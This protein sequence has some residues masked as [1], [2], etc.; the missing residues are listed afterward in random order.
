MQ[1]EFCRVGDL[2]PYARNARTHS[3]EQIAQIAA[4]IDEFGMVGAVVVRDGVIAKGHGTLA[5]LRKLYAAGMSVYPPPGRQHGAQPFAADAVP[6]IDATGWTDAQFRAYVI[7]DNKLSENAGWDRELLALEIGDLHAEGFNLDLLGFEVADLDVLLNVEAPQY[8]TDEDDTPAVEALGVSELGDIWKCGNHRVMC[9]DSTVS[10][11][12]ERLMA[13][14]VAALLHADPPYGMGKERDGVLN[15]NLYGDELSRFQMAWWSAYRPHLVSN[16]SAYVWGSAPDLWRFWYRAGL[17]DTERLELRNEIVWDKKTIPGMASPDLTQ[18]PEASERCLFF[19]LGNQFIGNVNSEDFPEV[20][21]PLRGYLAGEA[22]IAGISTADIKRLCG[23]GMHSHW[24]TR[25]QYTLIPE[26][27]YETLG[28]AYPGR[29]TRQWSELKAEWTSVRSS[30]RS[31]INA[32]LGVTRSY[33]DNAHQAMRDVWEF[34]RVV[35]DE[36]LGHATP[37]P[38]AMV[39]RIMVSSLDEGDVAVEPFGGSGS[40]L[41]GA[42]K[43]GRV[44]H[45]MELDPRYVD[46]IVRRWQNFTGKSALS[47]ASGEPFSTLEERRRI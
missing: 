32:K 27:H 35:G 2:I 11:D 40:T 29:F 25:S 15:D 44:C 10:Q 26:S 30:A 16:A 39:E 18:Y 23:C 22:A 46:V 38:V 34:P 9:G 43:T 24:F 41:I 17:C 1:I 6:V 4:S 20:W 5:A 42:E 12:V 13:G 36:R 47:E 8:L 33:F 31:V 14:S 19:Q 37:K 7:A 3:D 45:V 21:E 28:Q